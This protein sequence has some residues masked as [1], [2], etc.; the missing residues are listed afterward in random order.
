MANL[1]ITTSCNRHC[2]YCFAAGE[3]RRGSSHMPSETFDKAL[4]FLL[5][6]GIEQARLL[7]G[8]P[9]LHP[10][11]IR[12]AESALRRGLRLL[13]FSNGLMPERV[14]RW[15]EHSPH[16]AVALLINA[17]R[18]DHQKQL[19]TL[20][21]LGN[22]VMLGFNIHTPVFQPEFLLDLIDK[23]GLYPR[24]RFGLAHPCLDGSNVSIHPRLYCAVGNR[25]MDFA[26]LAHGSSVELEF[27]CGFVPCM[28]PPGSMEALGNTAAD[29][30]PRCSPVLDLRPDGMFGSC[31]PLSGLHQEVLQDHDT[32]GALRSR[33]EARLVGL[34]RLGIFP[35]CATCEM[36]TSGKC[37]GGCLAAA[38]QRLRPAV[39]ESRVMD[40]PTVPQWVLP[41]VDQPIAFWEKIHA[42]FGKHIREIYFPLPGGILGSGRP[43]QPDTHLGDFLRHSP[44]RRSVLLNPIIL[45]QPVDEI[46]PAIIE[47][48]QRLIGEFGISSAAVS[49]LMLGVRIRESLP[50]FPLTAS[51]LMDIALPNQALMLKG[52]CDTLVPSS[53]IM[54]DLRALRALRGAFP[55]TIRLIANE[56]CIPGCPH[57][58]QHFYEMAAD[59]ADPQSLCN[60]LLEEIP[61]MRL[62]GSWVLPQHLHL[63]RGVC[64]EWKLSGRVTLRD[65]ATYLRVAGAYIHR[66]PLAPHQIGGGPASI[67]EPIEITEEFYNRTLHCRRNCHQCGVCREYEAAMRLE[68]PIQWTGLVDESMENA[69]EISTVSS[70]FEIKGVL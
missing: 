62:T 34:R 22:R 42:E 8:E 43:P 39:R 45:P 2:S 10:E 29:I 26:A 60:D 46:A 19:D 31:F 63:F 56:G 49:N 15:L 7:G 37:T 50:E 28:F 48:L 6:S 59:P 52:I 5:R 44:L 4:D 64:D 35:E 24:I 54:R 36:R 30:G 47:A 12:L 9:T 14:L 51:T 70:G 1:C 27:D 53:R 21:R 13:V 16:G 38:M 17:T 41:Y 40:G 68:Y 61:W 32:A 18:T 66:R 69:R 65:A 67:L 58:T 55:G 23:Y 11:F 3:R 25:L 57:R 33:F 20:R